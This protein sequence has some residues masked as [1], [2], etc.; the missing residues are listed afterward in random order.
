MPTRLLPQFPPTPSGELEGMTQ[1]LN[2]PAIVRQPQ[3]RLPIPQS[4]PIE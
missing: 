2:M 4:L 3:G 1:D